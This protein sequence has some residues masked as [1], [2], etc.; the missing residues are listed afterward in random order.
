VSTIR[1]NLVE[2]MQ[3][4]LKCA[5]KHEIPVRD[6]LLEH[7]EL[8][9]G[10]NAFG[11]NE[12]S[13]SLMEALSILWGEELVQSAFQ[14]RDETVIPDHMDYFFGRLDEI[15]TEDYSPTD[16]DI[17]RARVRSVGIENVTFNL[18]GALI[19][20]YD[21]GGQ[22]NERAK[23]QQIMS[24]VAGVAFCVSFADFDR[25]MFEALPTIQP[26]VLDAL[27]IF[28]ELT[29]KEKFAE[30][31]F[32]LICTKFDRFAEKVRTTD[33]FG[34]MFPDYG[35][36]VHDPDECGKY[37]ANLFVE[38]AG[39]QIPERPILVYRQDSLNPENVRQNTNEICRYI[40]EHYFEDE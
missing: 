18:E 11:V 7:A 27:A 2:T 38:R 12:L 9:C 36:D 14:R 19:R 33:C 6:D 20:I 13:A 30:T 39:P 16:E 34:T 5:E 15:C 1:G 10:T 35:G 24:E 25:P 23:W 29:H 3:E 40:K 37:L 28:E 32:F 31:P 4:L 22:K 17:L 8:V 21:V 26:R